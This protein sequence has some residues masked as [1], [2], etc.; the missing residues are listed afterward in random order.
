MKF[1]VW[2]D[3][4]YQSSYFKSRP[5]PVISEG[6]GG[7]G[8]KSWKTLGT[9][10]L[11]LNLVRKISRSPRFVIDITGTDMLCLEEWGGGLIL[12]IRKNEVF[13]TYERK[14]RS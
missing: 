4:V 14:I 12:E 2:K 8:L 11:G 10:A 7:G 9:E 5:D 3:I 1:D 13:L 6:A